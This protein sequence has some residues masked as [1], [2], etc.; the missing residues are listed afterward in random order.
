MKE[1]VGGC[2]TLL[3]GAQVSRDQEE[4]KA[5]SE[6]QFILTQKETRLVEL[7]PEV[8]RDAFE[9]AAE[10][11][12][13]APKQP[14]VFSFDDLDLMDEA[15]VQ[16]RVEESR[17]L[18][19]TMLATDA[20]LAELNP[21]ICAVQGLSSVRTDGNPFRP[22]IYI[23]ALGKVIKQVNV[24]DGTA[25]LWMKFMCVA[26][27]KE[28]AAAYSRT[29]KFLRAQG[30]ARA[31]Y[32]VNFGP[33]GSGNDDGDLG[34]F[35]D[36]FEEPEEAPAAPRARRAPDAPG[37]MMQ[38]AYAGV[39]V[40]GVPVQGIPVSGVPM[41]APAGP[42]VVL[43][44][45]QLRRLLAGELDD[46]PYVGAAIPGMAGMP[47]MPMRPMAPVVAPGFE[48]TV[49]ASLDML[50]EMQQ[51]DPRS[52][53]G[54]S[55]A[56]L[57]G[58]AGMSGLSGMSQMPGMGSGMG[59]SGLSSTG[60]GSA[61]AGKDG[62]T[63]SQ[64]LS[65]QVVTLMIESIMRDTRLLGPV[66]ALVRRLEVPLL[67]LALTDPRFFSEKSHPARRL[68]DELTQRS[69]AFDSLSAPGFDAWLKPAEE[70]IRE[71]AVVPIENG[72]PFQLTLDVMLQA[73][74]ELENVE[75]ESR[76]KAVQAL[77]HAEQRNLL[78][79][80]TA[81][82]IRTRPD[83]AKAPDRVLAFLC[84]PW[85]QVIAESKLEDR[86]GSSDP[87]G[88]QRVVG[89]L[90][91]SATVELAAK[92]VA[93]LIK[94]IPG[95]L[96]KLREGLKRIGYPADKTSQFLDVLMSLHRDAMNAAK[97]IG[98][99]GGLQLP[100]IHLP[101]QTD[102]PKETEEEQ[103]PWLAPAERKDASYIDVATM[104]LLEGGAEPDFVGPIKKRA[105][106]EP[107]PRTKLSKRL[108][109]DLAAP[110]PSTA[111]EPAK[112]NEA[113]A[114]G[115]DKE[116]QLEARASTIEAPAELS[117]DA[118]QGSA[119]EPEEND[120]AQDQQD[121]SDSELV[122][123]AP[124][125][126]G[127]LLVNDNWLRVQLTWASPHGTMFMFTSGIGTTHSMTRRLFDKLV[128]AGSLRVIAD[129]PVVE[130][131]LDEVAETALRNSS[132]VVI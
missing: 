85:S 124:G 32:S 62:L 80:K 12:Q 116:L 77:M 57:T 78:A 56:G 99:G 38:P 44:I 42:G 18:Q 125:A 112:A 50:Q 127:E 58:L 3:M 97:Q 96:G 6:A 59:T 81:Q 117:A 67:A 126:W 23:K 128:R 54:S 10:G 25:S 8:L 19:T 132:E 4:R 7:F 121:V 100:E 20:E 98:S 110:E 41:A 47:V 93:R 2:R 31:G 76:E 22:E 64:V 101:P 35:D 46:S 26:L 43:T 71:L 92:N 123:L 69:F 120:K 109:T 118:E 70:A 105:V 39:P 90:I 65:Q 115:Q 16:V 66:R 49:P 36:E 9:D 33:Y 40:A 72:E 106:W 37:V 1:L 129:K 21:L 113:D 87:G 119:A 53:Y 24:E 84:G 34:D 108:L 94:L 17:A 103:G 5:A 111:A 48:Y 91:W 55:Q 102:E 27:G 95:L 75:R 60:Y 30:V 13:D 52:M 11:E 28:L 51:A 130:G 83:V 63:M 122:D 45:Q 89:D 88:Y 82:E 86:T 107:L 114:D 29:S 68:L 74:S 15:K 104:R 14:V 131:A 61:P 73:W 79:T